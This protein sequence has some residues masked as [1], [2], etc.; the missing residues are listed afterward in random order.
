MINETLLTRIGAVVRLWVDV[1]YDHRLMA[2]CASCDSTLPD[3]ARFCPS[4]GTEVAPLAVE[5]RRVVTVVFA[6]LVGYTALSE[7]LDPERVK[8]LIDASFERLI[9]DITAFGGRVDKVLGDGILALFGAPVAHEDDADRAIRAA[10]QMHESLARFVA[11]QPDLDGPLQLRIGVNTGEVVVGNVS[12]TAEYTAMGDVVNVA[13]RL[14]TLAEPGGILIGDSTA[15]LASEEILRQ[16]VDSVDV[17]G[18]EQPERVWLVTGRRRRV[19]TIGARFYDV[20]FVGRSTQW[21]LLASVMAMVANGRSAIVAVAGEAGAGKTRLVAEALDSFPSRAVTVFA[22]ACAPYGETNVWAPIA[23]ALFRRLDLDQDAP[24]ALLREVVR[25]KGVELYGFDADDPVLQRFVEGV[26]HLLGNPSELDDAPPAQAREILFSL[27]VEGLRRRT[28]SGPVVLWIDDLQWA[29]VLIIE[30]LHR[31]ARSLVDRPLLIVTAQRDDVDVDWPPV[32]DQPVTVRMPLDPLSRGE[33]TRL[34]G[35]VLGSS[36]SA[37]FVDSIYERSGGNPL[38]LIELAELAKSNPTSTALPGSLRALISARLDQLLPAQRS[39]IDNA[40][41][42]GASGQVESLHKFAA[43]MGQDFELDDLESLDQHGLLEIE[44]PT[45]RFRSDVVREVAYQTLTKLVRAQRHGGTAAVMSRDPRIPIDQVA[46]HAACAAELA[47][48]IGP[49]PGLPADIADRAVGLLFDAAKRAMDVGAFN[50]VR[51]QATRALDLG[52]SDAVVARELLL[53]RAQAQAERRVVAPALADAEDALDAAVAAGDRRQEGVARRLLGVLHQRDGDLAGARNELGAS[54]DIFRE[55]G[56]DAEL[57][58]SLRERGLAEVFGGSLGDAEWLLGEA[59]AL[60]ERMHDLRGRAWVRQHQAWVAFLS[61]DAELAE[62]RLLTAAQ[63]FDLLGD[64][65]GR[66]WASGLLAYVRFY[67]RRFEEAEALA[68]EVRRDSLELGDPWAPAMMDSLIAAIRLWSS[69]FVEA[70]ELSRR[71][72]TS[73]RELGDKFG[74]VQALSP[75]MRALVALGRTHEAERGIEESLALSDSFGDLSFPMMA[76]AGTAVHLGLGERAL[77]ISEQALDRSVAMGADGSESRITLA[78]ALCQVGRADEALATLDDVENLTPYLCAVRALARASTADAVGAIDDAELVWADSGAS[79]LDRV[80]AG[81][82]AAA[83]QMQLGDRE[84]AI[85]QLDRALATAAG[86]GD[87]VARELV[88]LT[89]SVVLS[90]G[91]R[92][93]LDHLGAGWRVVAESLATLVVDRP[94]EPVA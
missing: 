78:L 38:F 68:L 25:A 7:H 42:L 12:G 74:V 67:Q 84:S 41:V 71:A 20:P 17:R 57:A 86:A 27:I 88:A 31:I 51:R 21:E 48:E 93:E 34:V 14:Q 80:M 56:D 40:S 87:V 35:A 62:S 24:P 28:R 69:R 72:L 59:E 15:A 82:A 11:E 65:F 45:W 32:S 90:E 49:V 61:G 22:G 58:S 50:Q 46:H 37:A 13:S 19:P 66:G 47:A 2:T 60:T 91:T 36:A 18:R 9:A 85:E 16:S 4:C 43:E 83:A 30:L 10:L 76:A 8:R 92:H 39:I 89:R 44:G 94:E 54:V 64:R 6:D 63:E 79:Y 75:R 5:E 3:G 55:L 70:E 29:D 52:P 81:T 53:L 23:T 77:T 73:F 33:A 26:L 1:P